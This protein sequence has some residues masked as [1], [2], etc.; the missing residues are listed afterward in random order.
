MFFLFSPA[1]SG[2][3]YSVLEDAIFGL[4]Q[5]SHFLVSRSPGSHC[6]FSLLLLRFLFLYPICITVVFPFPSRSITKNATVLTSSLEIG[7]THSLLLWRSIYQPP[8]ALFI[9]YLLVTLCSW[10][11]STLTGSL[12]LIVVYYSRILLSYTCVIHS[13][14]TPNSYMC[15]FFFRPLFRYLVDRSIFTSA[16]LKTRRHQGLP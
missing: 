11:L 3:C 13:M 15:V 16:Y 9:R 4:A 6:F 7:L 5:R 2:K 1:S 12:L 14:N 8:L 10:V